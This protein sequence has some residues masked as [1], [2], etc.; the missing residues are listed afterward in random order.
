MFMKTSSKRYR[1]AVL[2]VF[3]PA[4][5]AALPTSALAQG[6]I[7]RCHALN[8]DLQFQDKPCN[9]AAGTREA[10]NNSEGEIIPAAPP[11]ADDATPVVE[12]YTRYLDLVARDRREQQAADEASAARL[13]AQTEAE[14]PPA[15]AARSYRSDCS[16]FGPSGECV[17]SAYQP[18][19][20]FFLQQPHYPR[21]PGPYRAPPP[22][23]D[24]RSDDHP[25][26][27]P[28]RV[29]RDARAEILQIN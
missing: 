6:T 16:L 18:P 14:R 9:T 23:R 11:P 27:P 15:L 2:M 24:P 26:N 20:A 5:F 17:E 3:L 10:K 28:P 12:R 4:V 19:H 29:P 1:V 13:K 7:Y 21:Y 22:V 25:Y 8:G